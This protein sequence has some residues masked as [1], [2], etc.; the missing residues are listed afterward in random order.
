MY[1]SPHPHLNLDIPL[2]KHSRDLNPFDRDLQSRAESKV[3]ESGDNSRLQAEDKA[4]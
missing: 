1:F 2:A 4:D 3:G